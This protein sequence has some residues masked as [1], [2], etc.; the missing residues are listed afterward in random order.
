MIHTAAD[1]CHLIQNGCYDSQRSLRMAQERFE[2]NGLAM[3][4][5]RVICEMESQMPKQ[6][7][8]MEMNTVSS[9]SSQA[10][11]LEMAEAPSRPV[12]IPVKQLEPDR[13]FT[14]N[15]GL[16]IEAMIPS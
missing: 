10:M 14:Q 13:Q 9:P 8:L 15:Q 5:H 1:F 16:P 11:P 7:P 4:V 3:T 6:S 12:R 2:Q